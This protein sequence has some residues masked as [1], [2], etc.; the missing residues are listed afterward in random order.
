MFTYTL[1]H[2]DYGNIYEVFRRP[3]VLGGRGNSGA[4]AVLSAPALINSDGLGTRLGVTLH[5]NFET[6]I[7]Q[8][9]C[10]S[11]AGT[12]LQVEFM[13]PCTC[14]CVGVHVSVC[15]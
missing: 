6:E 14:V 11:V 13:G 10:T 9:M 1:L 2:V 15:V 7:I 3:P 12:H 8:V 4:Q 5:L